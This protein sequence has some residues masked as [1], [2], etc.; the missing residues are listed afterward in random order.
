MGTPRIGEQI[1]YLTVCIMGGFGLTTVVACVVAR[2]RGASARPLAVKY[3]VWFAMIPPILLP[4]VYSR[5]LFQAVVLL[6]SLQCVREFNRVTGLWQD[7]PVAW[8]CYGLVVGMY[9]P[10]FGGWYGL[11]QAGPMLA[12]GVLLLVP[13]ARGRYRHMLQTVC[14]SIL[15]VLYF[16]WFLSH[17]AYLR[18][19]AHGVACAFYLLV[20]VACNDA[21]GYLWGTWLGRH[22][23]IPRISPS[24]TIEGAVLA[25]ASVVLMGYLLGRALPGIDPVAAAL[26]AVPVAV[27]GTCGDLVVSFIKR[28]VRVKDMGRAIPGHG[29][30]LDRCDSL[31]LTAPAFFHVVRYFVK[32]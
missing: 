6:L 26:L 13:I 3:L 21:F 19:L 30:I 28:D 14:L 11:H 1:L 17:L 27:L 7:R 8:L 32:A 20:L 10:V 9:V 4:L 15:A 12:V 22:K 18:D 16:G 24:K 29:G 25:S 5:M 23:L 2:V 31:I